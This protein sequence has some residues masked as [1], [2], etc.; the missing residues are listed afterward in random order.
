MKKQLILIAV[1]GAIFP[2]VALGGSAAKISFGS[3]LKGGAETPKGAPAGKGT[4]AVTIT[5]TKV[6]WRLTYSGIDKPTAAHIHKGRP[7]VA[8]PVVVPFG[9]AF[10]PIGCIASTAAVVKG[11]ETN[12]AGYYVNIHTAKFPGVAV[13]GQLKKQ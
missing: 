12:P 8:G 3:T 1:I 6:C 10:K 13:R 11:I 5:G 7:G 2:A 9:A 4:A